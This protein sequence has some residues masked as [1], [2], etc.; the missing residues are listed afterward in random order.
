LAGIER[1]IG[2]ETRNE[3]YILT[4]TKN[5]RSLDIIKGELVVETS[6]YYLS[7]FMDNYKGYLLLGKALLLKLD[8][9]S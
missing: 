9:L 8:G 3:T 1:L 2:T 4:G 7:L 5:F 6:E